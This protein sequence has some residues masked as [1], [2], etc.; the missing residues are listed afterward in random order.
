MITL[1]MEYQMEG[2]GIFWCLV[3]MLHEQGGYI[4]T[5]YERIAYELRTDSNKV[6]WIIEQ[7]GLFKINDDKFYS[8]SALQRILKR[9]E[10]AKKPLNQ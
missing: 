6:K 7:S 10:K 5:E 2:I 1:Q 3:E 9:D 4:R 8:E